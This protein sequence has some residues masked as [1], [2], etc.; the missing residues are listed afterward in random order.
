MKYGTILGV[1][2]KVS[3]L[4]IGSM[5]F[6]PEQ[7]ALSYSLLDE[8]FAAGGN[9]IDTAYIY[10]GG[11]SER[12]IGMWMEERKNRSAVFLVDKGAHPTAAGQRA[13]LAPEEIEH[14]LQESLTRLQTDSI[15]LYMLHRDDSDVPVS[16]VID[17]LNQEIKAGRIQ[18]IGASN[19][20]HERVQEAN[21]YAAKRGLKGFVVISN[22]L[23]LAVPMEPIWGGVVSVSKA[24]YDWHRETQ[25]PLMPW[26]SQARGFFSGRFT[27]DNREDKGMV[28]VYYN[29]ANFERFRRAQMLGEKKGYSAIQIALAYVLHQPFPIFPIVGPVSLEE[30]SSCLGALEI[31]LSEHEMRWLNLEE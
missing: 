8:F 18:A 25:F 9:A 6:S 16:T 12:L 31:Q 2:T 26:S 27:P 5:I 24:A 23:S 3:Q 11:N 29:E 19:W 21:E 28:R 7:A 13:R 1:E 22:N 10:G 4:V 15:D 14:D 30:L 17:Y 20:E